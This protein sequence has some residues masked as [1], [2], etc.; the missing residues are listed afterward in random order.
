AHARGD[1]VAR[2]RLGIEVAAT[3]DADEPSAG[4][5]DEHVA[6]P[7]RARPRVRLVAE[8]L[9]RDADDGI[10]VEGVRPAD[11]ASRPRALDVE[12]RHANIC[13]GTESDP[14]DPHGAPPAPP[15]YTPLAGYDNP[16]VRLHSSTVKLHSP[17]GVRLQRSVRVTSTW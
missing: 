2:L 17:S 13:A 3:Q 15:H 14:L 7:K 8:R 12:R 5:G 4:R 1:G 16:I 10:S 6:Y 9:G 11:L